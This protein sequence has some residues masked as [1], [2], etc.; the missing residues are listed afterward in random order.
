MSKEKTVNRFISLFL[1]LFISCFASA[2]CL[3]DTPGIIWKGTD[4]HISFEKL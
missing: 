3:I 2:Q 1:F 4:N